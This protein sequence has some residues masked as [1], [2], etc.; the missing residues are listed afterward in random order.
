MKNHGRFTAGLMSRWIAG[1]LA[2]WKSGS[3]EI[4]RSTTL[5]TQTHKHRERQTEE[6]QRKGKKHQKH[7]E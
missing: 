1:V 7:Q 6:T 3:R 5:M 2:D 4:E